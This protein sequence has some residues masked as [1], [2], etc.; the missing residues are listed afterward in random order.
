MRRWL[1]KTKAASVKNSMSTQETFMKLP[2]SAGPSLKHVGIESTC[3]IVPP[4][5]LLEEIRNLNVPVVKTK[6]FFQK[7][8]KTRLK[9]L[10][11]I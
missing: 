11:D 5:F 7:A 10:R 2:L 9:T 8:K 1:K 3:Y 4:Y 6:D